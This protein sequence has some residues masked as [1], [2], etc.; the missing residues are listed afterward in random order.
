MRIS[1]L[2]FVVVCLVVC[3]AAPRISAQAEA[4]I[5]GDLS[6]PPITKVNAV[7]TSASTTAE[8]SEM[9]RNFLLARRN[10]LRL[11]LISQLD[12]LRDYRAKTGNLLPPTEIALINDTIVELEK[13]LQIL[14]SGSAQLS[15]ASA[16]SIPAQGSTS[17]PP[18]AH[19]ACKPAQDTD[20]CLGAPTHKATDQP[21]ELVL[22]W[23]EPQKSVQ[24]YRVQVSDDEFFTVLRVD[25]D[26]DLDPNIS[27]GEFTLRQ[28]H[29]L[30]RG[31]T[32]HWRVR[33]DFT[34]GTSAW[35]QNGVYYLTT[36][37]NIFQALSDKGFQLQKA[38]VGPDKGELAEFGFL[39][40]VG[41]KTVFSTTFALSWAPKKRGI[42]LGRTN[43][44]P[45]WSIE[46]AL[47]S[48]ESE[49]ED[50]WRFRLSGIF[51]TNF[52]GCKV[53]GRGCPPEQLTSPT[54]EGLYY[55]GSLKLEGDKDFD[56]RKLSGE[57]LI[58]PNSFAL[59]MGTA[60]PGSPSKPLQFQWRPFF[61]LD[62][63]HTFRRGDSEERENTILRL[64]PRVRAR[65]DLQFLRQWLNMSEV[66]IF[67]DETFYYLPL[68]NRRRRNNF[69]TSGIEFN[70]T[71]NLGFGLTY[72]NGRS[73]PKF[74]KIN[75]LQGILGIRF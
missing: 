37:N 66:A 49:A 48:D 58:T 30:I 21:L 53:E 7:D 64:V 9:N 74:E 56:V 73:A 41:E 69:F 32:Y 22:G 5:T 16:T 4:P 15:S 43:L 33:A 20:F 17:T 39:S 71:P 1:I 13:D 44:R 2:T 50:A 40:T 57:F 61:N 46:G 36:G 70:F 19:R 67:A 11:V 24:K 23:T 47:A 75:T 3:A 38:L 8:L 59:A 45:G 18:L 34:D 14:D 27:G 65:V 51:T 68:E 60:R 12:A 42:N 29:R 62:A 6:K 25:E 10:Q 31:H 28:R 63:G 54:F 52:I 55:T 26:V 35:A 72:K